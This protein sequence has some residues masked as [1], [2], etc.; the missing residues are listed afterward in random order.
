M[1]FWQYP[2]YA[3]TFCCHQPGIVGNTVIQATL[4]RMS[5]CALYPLNVA[6]QKN[7]SLYLHLGGL[8]SGLSFLSTITGP[9]YA[10]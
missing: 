1:T 4:L 8:V 6:L 5:P 9:Q 2:M 3:N 10:S 7:H